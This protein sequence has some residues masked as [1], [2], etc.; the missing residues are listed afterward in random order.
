M[1]DG[2]NYDMSLWQ[3]HRLGPRDL[4]VPLT[5]CVPAELTSSYLD[6]KPAN[7]SIC[8]ELLPEH[9]TPFRYGQVCLPLFHYCF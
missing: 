2:R 6:P 5:C 8:Q 9:F 3:L 7:E 1:T 4:I